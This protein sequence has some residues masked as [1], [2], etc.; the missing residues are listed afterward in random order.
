MRFVLN[1]MKGRPRVKQIRRPETAADQ[2]IPTCFRLKPEKKI[3]DI[4]INYFPGK[5]KRIHKNKR[6]QDSEKA[7]TLLLSMGMY[8]I[9]DV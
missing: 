3:T 8:T 9:S 7:S 6:T 1:L 5:T 4:M 2:S